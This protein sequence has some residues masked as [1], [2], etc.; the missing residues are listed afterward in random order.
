MYLLACIYEEHDIVEEDGQAESTDRA[1]CL[2]QEM[3]N[4]AMLSKF[5]K[6]YIT[7][8]IYPKLGL[9][10]EQKNDVDASRACFASAI[11]AQRQWFGDSQ[12]QLFKTLLDLGVCH[13][14]LGRDGLI[15]AEQCIKEST[16]LRER[17]LHGSVVE[18]RQLLCLAEGYLA[19]IPLYMAKQEVLKCKALIEKAFHIR[20]YVYSGGMHSAIAECLVEYG[21][22]CKAMKKHSEAVAYLEASLKVRHR[23]MFFTCASLLM[24]GLAGLLACWFVCCL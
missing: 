3:Q 23:W 20:C 7:A 2:L 19:Q 16:E 18:Q 17:Y 22:L 12:P 4:D 14:Q 5:E 21:L 11:A 10:F 15:A 6:N 1:I 8:F 13:L 24:H 9:L